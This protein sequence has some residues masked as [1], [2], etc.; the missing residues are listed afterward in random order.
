MSLRDFLQFPLLQTNES[1]NKYGMIDQYIFSL[2]DRIE[3]T[4]RICDGLIHMRSMNF[5]HRD[6]KLSNILIR[7]DKKMKRWQKEDETAVVI[8]DF[9]ISR[10]FDEIDTIYGLGTA[11]WAPPEQW[12]SKS[13]GVDERESYEDSFAFG[14]LIVYMFANW[15]LAAK[16]IF[17]PMQQFQRYVNQTDFNFDIKNHKFAQKS[18]HD[19]ARYF[20]KNN[21]TLYY[22]MKKIRTFKLRSYTNRCTIN[23][24]S[25]QKRKT[26]KRPRKKLHKSSNDLLYECLKNEIVS[27][28]VEVEP[29]KRLDLQT[30]KTWLIQINKKFTEEKFLLLDSFFKISDGAIDITQTS[31][32]LMDIIRD[33]RYLT[34]IDNEKRLTQQ[35]TNLC[36]AIS[37]MRL[38]CYALLDFLETRYRANVSIRE[39]ERNRNLILKD[40]S[41]F[42]KQLVNICC[43][44]ISP[45][46]LDGLN[47]GCLENEHHIA[48]QQQNISKFRF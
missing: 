29:K 41:G 38:L 7:V 18:R 31:F 8:T 9:G 19:L 45:R 23:S 16:L 37:A 5:A 27:K 12:L 34:T 47:H 20:K 26:S 39:K 48:V 40:D 42:L 46:S 11:G 21:C 2:R 14:R 30:A 44:V 15:N 25:V 36:V 24:T 3:M 6:I 43:G 13:I 35:S 33:S 4:S 32:K 10:S 17:F 28:L 22:T 1:M